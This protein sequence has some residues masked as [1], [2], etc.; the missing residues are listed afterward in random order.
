MQKT[1]KG[2]AF[3]PKAIERRTKV[4]QHLENQLKKGTKNVK[5]EE[6]IVELPLVEKDVK[7]IKKE[8]LTLKTRI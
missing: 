1:K 2:Y 4:I 5:Q 6:K 3:N 8:L 7:R